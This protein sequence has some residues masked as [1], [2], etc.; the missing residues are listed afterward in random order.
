MW[1][2]GVGGLRLSTSAPGEVDMSDTERIEEL[3][4]V[5]NE[6]AVRLATAH[7]LLSIAKSLEFMCDATRRVIYPMTILG[8]EHLAQGAGP[9]PS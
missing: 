9:A 6:W 4:S 3:L 2:G 7:S 8:E 5:G 1:Y